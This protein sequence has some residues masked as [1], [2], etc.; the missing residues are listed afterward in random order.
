MPKE[1]PQLKNKNIDMAE[2]LAA[3]VREAGGRAYY[4]GG[5]VRDQLLGRENKDIDIEVHG[6][7]VQ[8]LSDILDSLGERTAMGASFGV[9]GLRHY[10]I[11]IAMPRSEVATGRGHRDFAV[12]VDPF[13]GEEKA[14]RRRDFT[15]NAMMEDVLTGEILDFFGGKTD[16][17]KKLIRHV[18]DLTY[19]ED[20]LRV[21]R[22]AQFSA[23]F[24]FDVAEETIAL[25]AAM[26]LDALAR[27]RVMGEMEKALLKAERPAV[28]FMQVKRMEQLEPWFGE[29]AGSWDACMAALDR[30]ARRRGE[31]AQPLNYML[32]ALCAP[33]AP[34]AADR[35]MDRL[36]GRVQTVQ[37]VRSMNALHRKIAGVPLSDPDGWMALYDAALCPEDLPL[38]EC[39]AS[40]AGAEAER[41]MRDLLTLYRN[42]MA[43]PY[44]MGRDLLKA[45]MRPGARMGEAL[46]SAHR[47]RLQGASKAEQIAAAMEILKAENGGDP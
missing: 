8:T 23:R 38:L 28:F 18:D 32:A 27:E 40:D 7:P 17:E 30:A 21:L 44:A 3:R 22:A 31:A 13:I 9:M 14:A 29:L 46:A 16:L 47:L 4:V 24:G 10:D 2:Q 42:R 19:A 34:E 26:A 6:I 45:G 11:D 36:C 41:K 15:I 25:G 20:P 33:L 39:A 43:Q 5:Y 1:M 12:F 37:Y 35:L